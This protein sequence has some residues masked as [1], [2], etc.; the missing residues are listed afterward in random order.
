MSTGPSLPA[1]RQAKIALCLMAL[2]FA[3]ALVSAATAHASEY[4]MLLCA[5]NVGSNGYTTATN[6]I[7]PQHPSG[8]FDFENHCGPAPDPAGNGAFLRIAEHEASGNAGQGAYGAIV[9]TAPP[10]VAIG[11]AGGYTREPNAFNEG[12]RGQ[13]WGEDFAGNGTLILNQGA[14]LPN[15]GVNWATTATFAPHL[16]PYGGSSFFRSLVFELACVRPAG[17]DR[18]NYNGV[19]TNTLIFTLHDTQNAQIALTNDSVLMNAGWARGAQPVTYNVADNGSGLRWERVRVDGVV[20]FTLDH[21]SA[22]DLGYSQANLEFARVFQPCPTGGPYAHSFNL[23]TATLSDGAHILQA[24]DQDY[25]QAVGLNGSGSESCDQ[26][27]VYTDNTAPGAPGGLRVTSANPQRYLDQVGAIFSLPPNSGSPIAKVHYEIL[28]VAGKVVVPEKVV[29]GTNP[30][31]LAKVEGPKAP[32]VY[33]L[34]VWLEDA[35]GFAGPAAVAPIPHDTTPPAAPQDVSVTA[36]S[37]PR[38]ADGFDLRWRNILDAG[39]PIDS[40]RYQVLD[41]TGKVVVPTTVAGAN[42]EAIA[43]LEAPSAAGSYQLRLWLTD[44]EGNVGAPVSAP[45]AYDCIRSVAGTGTQLS[46]GFAGQRTQTV[47]QGAGAVL[48]GALRSRDGGPVASAPVCLYGRVV[49]D[50]GRDFLGIALTDPGGG[51]RFPIPAGPSRELSA[52]YRPDQRQ[53]R[54]SAELRT[55]VHPTLRTPRAVVKNK[56]V[57]HFEGEIPGPHNDQVVIVLQVRSGKGWLAFRRYRTRNDGHYDLEYTFRRTTKATNYEMRAQIR[58]TTG[59]PYEQGDS[60]PLTLRVI[61]GRAKVPVGQPTQEK[62]RCGKGKHVVKRRGNVGCVKR[63]RGGQGMPSRHR[64][65][66]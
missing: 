18:A 38:A 7:S 8:I 19:D 20:R 30:T 37:T 35:V 16:W 44:A 61:P 39:A 32:G 49:T 11:A 14:G 41:G 6:T 1:S 66:V 55:V 15:S 5:G 62:R 25:G 65:G 31:E 64:A 10:W 48:S 50:D 3:I 51:Y 27:T 56:T 34:R 12:W 17:C 58:E 26:R 45:L 23:D 43:S 52:V 36:P 54:A 4:K 63:N 29:S 40:A 24:C 47:Q 57:A 2:S 33:Q 21:R 60:D 13:F 46:A 53:V 42:V 9:I 28:D 22:C 59:Y